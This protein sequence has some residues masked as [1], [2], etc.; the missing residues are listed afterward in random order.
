[1]FKNMPMKKFVSIILAVL[2]IPIYLISSYISYNNKKENFNYYEKSLVEVSIKA[3]INHLKEAQKVHEFIA[4]QYDSKM[5][6]EINRFNRS[7]EEHKGNPKAI[8]LLKVK[9]KG[10]NYLDYY[11]IDD[12]NIIINSTFKPV[13]GLD[14]SSD[15]AFTKALAKIRKNGQLT[16]SKITAERKTGK[17]R[18]WAYLPTKDKKYILEVGLANE[19][20]QKYLKPTTFNNL[21]EIVVNSSPMISS[22]TIYDSHHWN[23]TKKALETD[24]KV[25]KMLD[26][27]FLNKK[28]LDIYDNNGIIAKKL[29]YFNQS[30][31]KID[32]GGR[33]IEITYDNS[34]IKRVFAELRIEALLL[35]L[36]FV[37]LLIISINYFINKFVISP[38]TELKE[39]VNV[40]SRGDFSENKKIAL[41][42]EKYGKNEVGD[43]ASAFYKMAQ[44][45]ENT[46]VTKR[47]LENIIDSVGDALI[48]TDK[49]LKITDLNDY[50]VKSLGKEKSEILGQNLLEY[51]LEKDKLKKIIF[52][53]Q[54]ENKLKNFFQLE[55]TTMIVA[56][57]KI[58]VFVNIRGHFDDDGKI[59][60]FVFS[61]RN[62][63]KLRIMLDNMQ[64]KAKVLL[65]EA[66]HDSLTNCL[67]RRGL[68]EVFK[69][70]FYLDKN[71]IL[72]FSIVMFDIDD[73]PMGIKKG[74]LL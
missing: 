70:T 24:P 52:E 39:A 19:E 4:E 30:N 65:Q 12:K 5:R 51:F 68:E 9:A 53:L 54:N 59:A 62:I 49:R 3:A 71:N 63:T 48:I 23:L 57:K 1:M 67:N 38:I 13:L 21:E 69:N 58:P 31:E 2:L 46:L 20:I 17:L 56:K 25:L 11:I 7:Y 61:V 44:N 14:F 35:F 73:T 22:A 42:K 8:D 37:I 66:K 47:Y 28:T 33:V 6:T 74:M 45:L 41:L 26:Q 10:P 32:G 55:L 60:G 15:K 29:I 40:L 72:P 36:G 43:L 27:I 34:S 64:A 18:K 50:V 16:I